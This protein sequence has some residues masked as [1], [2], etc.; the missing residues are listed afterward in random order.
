MTNDL[1]HR[2]GG[3][4]TTVFW[5]AVVFASDE[6][7]F[8]AKTVNISI[9]GICVASPHMMELEHTYKI[10]LEVPSRGVGHKG[11][12]IEMHGKVAYQVMA[13]FE[14][15]VGIALSDMPDDLKKMIMEMLRLP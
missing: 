11:S 5:R 2:D 9:N 14:F 3:G 15:R 6:Q 10:I 7:F 1:D 8:K 4:R 12:Y 13:G